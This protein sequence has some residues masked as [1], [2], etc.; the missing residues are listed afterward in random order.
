MRAAGRFL[1]LG[2]GIRTSDAPFPGTSFVQ[3]AFGPDEAVPREIALRCTNAFGMFPRLL[4]AGDV[5]APF[6][7]G[8][9]VFQRIDKEMND[10]PAA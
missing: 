4:R 6:R 1:F 3:A 7:R 8:P 5:P 10:E 2:A 9:R